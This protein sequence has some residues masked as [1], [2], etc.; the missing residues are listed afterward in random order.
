[1]RLGGP[2]YIRFSAFAAKNTPRLEASVLSVSPAQLTDQQGKTYFLVQVALADGE[3]AKLP[4]GLELMPGMPAEVFI[5]T[6]ARSILSYFVKPLSDV[7]SRTF[8][9]S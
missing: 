3:L 7:L 2:A 5:E 8:R 1:M 9:E 4:A 6:G